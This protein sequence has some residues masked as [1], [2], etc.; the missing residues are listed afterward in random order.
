MWINALGRLNQVAVAAM[1]LMGFLDE[2][3]PPHCLAQ[4]FGQ[5]IVLG[6]TGPLELVRWLPKLSSLI[7]GTQPT[8]DPGRLAVD[9]YD[10]VYDCIG[11]PA[12][13]C[14]CIR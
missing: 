11:L 1:L 13:R 4:D 6:Q 7:T 10:I 9:G 14:T 3:P 2:V 5:C 12:I 8:G